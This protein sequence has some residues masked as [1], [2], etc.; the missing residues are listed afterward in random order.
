MSPSFQSKY[1]QR[2]DLSPRL[3]PSIPGIL[4]LPPS[5]GSRATEFQDTCT[6]VFQMCDQH[7]DYTRS[8]E[9]GF[10]MT[11]KNGEGSDERLS[12]CLLSQGQLQMPRIN[13]CLCGTMGREE[14]HDLSSN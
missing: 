3:P 6:P 11:L 10:C 13:L 12:C 9:D 1:T 2:S 14:K 8:K 4:D 5:T 7:A